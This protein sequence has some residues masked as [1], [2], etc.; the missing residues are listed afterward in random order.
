M[1]HIL[2]Q[3]RLEVYVAGSTLSMGLFLAGPWE[4]MDTTAYEVLNIMAPE[5][6][7]AWLFVSN[8]LSHIL[9]LMVNGRRWWSPIAR[10]G[11]CLISSGLYASWSIGFAAMDPTTTAV[12]GYAMP[13]IASGFCCVIAWR[14]ALFSMRVRDARL[15]A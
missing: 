5:A 7:W 15:A 11:T 12:V 14:D 4:S 8:G 13:A 2:N 9:W 10:W 3:R 1:R 6:L